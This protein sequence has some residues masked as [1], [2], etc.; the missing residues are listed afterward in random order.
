MMIYAVYYHKEKHSALR[1]VLLILLL[2]YFHF[3]H[4]VL[5]SYSAQRLRLEFDSQIIQ[6]AEFSF[7]GQWRQWGEES[8]CNLKLENYTDIEN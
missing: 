8:R 6:R 3:K 7:K 5:H 2:I 1:K 4:N